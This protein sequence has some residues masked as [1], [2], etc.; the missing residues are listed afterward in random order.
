MMQSPK[1]YNFADNWQQVLKHL[2]DWETKYVVKRV[3]NYLDERG[4]LMSDVKTPLERSPGQLFT[5][6]DY[7]CTT[8]MTLFENALKT[9][10]DKSFHLFTKEQHDYLNKRDE[11]E[12]KR[13]EKQEQD[14][15][16]SD[17][18]MDEEIDEK[19]HIVFYEIKEQV[20]DKLGYNFKTCQDK[21]I[22]YTPVGSCHSWNRIFGLWLA[23]KTIP[24]GKWEIRSSDK[25]TTV[26]SAS[27][28]MV[29]D[30]LYFFMMGN[31]ME[32]YMNGQY[33]SSADLDQTFGGNSAFIDSK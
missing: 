16:N 10:L 1:N 2:L 19:H 5:S 29:F 8:M 12:Q 11:L 28:N 22:F 33:N 4:H 6:C 27:K 15:D 18:E 7:F 3:Y 24:E 9:R 25:H 14:P 26:Y 13:Q 30:I 32:T 17:F 23:N 31:R 20:L 21:P